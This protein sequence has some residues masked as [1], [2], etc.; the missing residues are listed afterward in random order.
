MIFEKKQLSI[1][2]IIVFHIVG[3]IG[4]LTP[5]FHELFLTLV[6]FHLLLMAAILIIN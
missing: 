5:Y 6:P 2:F 1:I 4:L 3:L